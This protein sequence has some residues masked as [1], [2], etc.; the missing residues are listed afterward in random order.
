MAASPIKLTSADIPYT[1]TATNA[2]RFVCKAIRW[3]GGTTAGHKVVIQD[4]DSNNI[5]EAVATGANFTAFD[6]VNR[7]WPYGFKVT[8]LDSGT[9]YLEYGEP[10]Q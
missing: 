7:S 5:W 8:T 4:P 10:F 9:L 6:N 1:H 2:A 3:V